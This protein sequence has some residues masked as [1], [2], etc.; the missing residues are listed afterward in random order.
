MRRLASIIPEDR[1]LWVTRV[2]FG[3]RLTSYG[4][5]STLDPGSLGLTGRDHE[6]QGAAGPAGLIIPFRAKDHNNITGKGLECH[7][8]ATPKY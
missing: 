4:R 6:M 8:H 2:G 7:L 3:Q 1:Y 5:H